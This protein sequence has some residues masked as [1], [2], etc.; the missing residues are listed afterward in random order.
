MA[1]PFFFACQANVRRSLVNCGLLKLQH[2][3]LAC[4]C[5]L[6]CPSFSRVNHGA[7]V[8]QLN[9]VV[10]TLSR[11]V[12]CGKSCADR[13]RK[14]K[15]NRRLIQRSLLVYRSPTVGLIFAAILLHFI[16]VTPVIRAFCTDDARYVAW[17]ASKNRR[18]VF[19]G[20]CLLLYAVKLHGK[21][22]TPI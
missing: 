2:D 15:K 11:S 12:A 19:I 14:C 1:S 20:F 18:Q 3:W 21:V 13:V 17:Q 22:I 4:L 10:R 16:V 7:V 6:L 8:N 5:Q 9:P